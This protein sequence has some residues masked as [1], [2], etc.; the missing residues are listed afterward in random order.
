MFSGVGRIARVR[1]GGT[2]RGGALYARD[3]GG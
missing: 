1:D 3:G 2:K